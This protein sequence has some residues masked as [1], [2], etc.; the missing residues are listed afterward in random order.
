[1]PTSHTEPSGCGPGLSRPADTPQQGV[2]S[3][4]PEF[5]AAKEELALDVLIHRLARSVRTERKIDHRQIAQNASEIANKAL[6]L[7]DHYQTGDRGMAGTLGVSTADLA[8]SMAT[9][10]G[11]R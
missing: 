8:G 5:D 3:V 6:R 4:L 11:G 1:M 7:H 9:E 10:R 2:R